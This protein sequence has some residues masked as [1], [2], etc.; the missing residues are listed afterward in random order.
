M[1]DNKNVGE[2]N[3]AQQEIE[4]VGEGGQT[5]RQKVDRFD[6]NAD[7][8]IVYRETRDGEE[9]RALISDLF[10][11]QT[12]SKKPVYLKLCAYDKYGYKVHSWQPCCFGMFGYVVVP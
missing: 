12:E 7:I 5:S 1:E 3:A 4:V 9:K 11:I 2:L 6:F 8:E 10:K